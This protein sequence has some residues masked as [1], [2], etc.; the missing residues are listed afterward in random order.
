MTR[1]HGFP[2]VANTAARILILGSMP[3]QASLEANQ[4]YA[5]PRNAFWHIV[6]E[7]VG[8]A[9][10]APYAARTRALKSAGIA[11]WDVLQSCQ[12]QGSLD[13]MIQAETQAINDFQK[14]FRSHRR[15]TRIYFNGATAETIFKR[16]VLPALDKFSA[17]L[18]RLPSTSPAHA[19]MSF[20]EKLEAW[21]VILQPEKKKLIARNFQADR[22]A[23]SR[24][25]RRGLA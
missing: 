6:S 13:A 11:L 1:I 12:R 17:S 24:Y 4:Y 22:A 20:D 5:H 3:G 25:K 19:G 16:H 15:I 21:R 10:D 14:F 18:T 7:L 8:V 9:P 2:P 23:M